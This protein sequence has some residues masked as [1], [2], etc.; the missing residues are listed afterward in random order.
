MCL[1]CS[2]LAWDNKRHILFQATK[3]KTF[4]NLQFQISY[5]LLR[6][7]FSPFS[8]VNPKLKIIVYIFFVLKARSYVSTKERRW[9]LTH[10]ASVTKYSK[11][12]DLQLGLSATNQSYVITSSEKK[13][14]HIVSLGALENLFLFHRFSVAT[15]RRFLKLMLFSCCLVSQCIAMVLSK[16]LLKMEGCCNT[17]TLD[18]SSIAVVIA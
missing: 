17:T 6:D 1:S 11:N 10:K 9:K 12:L 13:S 3:K 7:I 2:S 4:S 5:C 8:L 16:H 18:S 15:G 14:N